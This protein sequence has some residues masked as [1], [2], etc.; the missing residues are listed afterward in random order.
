MPEAASHKFMILRQDYHEADTINRIWKTGLPM[1]AEN[2]MGQL[3]A[4]PVGP[5]NRVNSSVS[6]LGP[7]RVASA[8]TA[9]SLIATAVIVDADLAANY[10][11]PDGVVGSRSLLVMNILRI[12]TL[13]AA[14][15]SAIAGAKPGPAIPLSRQNLLGHQLK[16]PSRA[17]RL[18]S[19]TCDSDL[20]KTPRSAS[21]LANDPPTV[22]NTSGVSPNFQAAPWRAV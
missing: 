9:V 13:I 4:R 18:C 5:G 12:V 19:A 1:F 3:L 7:V 16:E 6:F 17:K 14:V 11:S 2:F 8:L 21:G 22:Q 15:G 10:L 20:E